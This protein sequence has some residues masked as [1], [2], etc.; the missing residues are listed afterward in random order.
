[1]NKVW[2]KLVDSRF[3]WV[4]GLKASH[5]LG[6]ILNALAITANSGTM[7]V[8]ISSSGEW[9]GSW[10]DGLHVPMTAASHLKILC[11]F[12]QIPGWD[13][14]FS[15]GDCFIIFSNAYFDLALLLWISYVL[16]VW[17][18]LAPTRRP[19]SPQKGHRS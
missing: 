13:G 3:V 17:P 18:G 8:K 4:L 9:L 15:V 11:D 12:L 14:I 19:T 1:M 5:L 2:Q 10:N 7:P 16:L 6:W